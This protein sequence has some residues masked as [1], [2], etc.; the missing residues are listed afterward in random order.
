[1]IAANRNSSQ[2]NPDQWPEFLDV[3][4]KLPVKPKHLQNAAAGTSSGSALARQSCIDLQQQ[5]KKHGVFQK[6]VAALCGSR[7]LVTRDS[8][9]WFVCSS[10]ARGIITAFESEV[11]QRLVYWNY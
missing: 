6:N 9:K 2:L 7:G 8:P 1:M 3:N 11:R 5:H 10:S 4:M